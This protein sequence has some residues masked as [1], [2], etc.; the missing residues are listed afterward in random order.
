MQRVVTVYHLTF[1]TSHAHA[2]LVHLCPK[3][4]TFPF[5]LW[6]ESVLSFYLLSGFGFSSEVCSQ[7][8]AISRVA[9]A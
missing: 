4:L 3:V 8:T 7:K 2:D 6:F 5:C 9:F 1:Q